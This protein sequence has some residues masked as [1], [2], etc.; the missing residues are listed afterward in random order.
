MRTA[1]IESLLDVAGRDRRVWLLTADLGY[2]VLERFAERFPERYVNVGVAEQNLIGVAAGLARCGKI[3]FVYS[4]ANFPTLRCYEQI[5]NDVCYHRGNVK[6]VVV[7]GG[8]AYGAQGYTHHGVEDL[9]VMRALPGMTVVAPADPVEAR[10]AT[11]ALVDCAGPCYLRLGKAKE[12][13]VH[14]GEP[15]F[16]LGRAVLVRQGRDLTL[17]STGAMLKECVEVAGRLEAEQVSARVLSMHTLKPL[18]EEAVLEAARETPAVI[19][20]EEHSVTGGLGAAVADVLAGS[21]LRLPRFRKFGLPDE[22]S[23]A[24][25]SQAYL[26]RRCGDLFEVALALARVRRAA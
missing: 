5:R 22:I 20:V 24:V 21:G 26:R 23:H 19:T 1:F 10:L 6:V 9:A 11:R 18:D 14:Q 3:P 4:I 16:H 7:G 15:A 13:V 8:L 25:G 17:I 12:P 2:S